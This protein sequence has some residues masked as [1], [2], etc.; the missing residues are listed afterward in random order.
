MLFRSSNASL[1]M[2]KNT[3]RVTA[4]LQEQF[5]L[6]AVMF[7]ENP[8]AF[9]SAN[10]TKFIQYACDLGWTVLLAPH[11]NKFGYP[12]LKSMFDVAMSTWDAEWYGY[13]NADMLFDASLL[14]T[15]EFIESKSDVITIPMLVGRRYN[16]EVSTD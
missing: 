9:V 12:V 5:N 3:V 7:I 8:G 1:Y 13:M 4:S 14:Q 15:I 6:K 10:E 11:C 16:V 2:F